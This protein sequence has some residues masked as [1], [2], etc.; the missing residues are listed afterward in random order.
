MSSQN[1]KNKQRNAYCNG[2]LKESRT[3]L[4]RILY[5]NASVRQKL[6]KINYDFE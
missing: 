6:K 4:K 2:S 3:K 1:K 5:F